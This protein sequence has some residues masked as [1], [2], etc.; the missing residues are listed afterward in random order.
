MFVL[1]LPKMASLPFFSMSES[2]ILVSVREK[3][4]T[5]SVNAEYLG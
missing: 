1:T 3:K 2:C 5:L 4:K